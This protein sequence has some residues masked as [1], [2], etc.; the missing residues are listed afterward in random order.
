MTNTDIEV[1]A[2]FPAD[3]AVVEGGKVYSNG[4]FWD[5]LRFPTYPQVFSLSLVAVLKI[6]FRAYHQDHRFEI[7][8]ED[9]DGK[10]LPLR[11][12]GDFR[13]GSSADMRYGDPTVM[14][15]AVNV[16]NVQVAKPADY[17]FVL[18]VDG[19]ELGRY[20]IRAVQL[21]LPIQVPPGTPPQTEPPG[22]GPA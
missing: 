14:P 9:A 13:V 8:M 15:I 3:H 10:E 19:A 22:E 4:A 6:P 18:R 5:R 21:A 17:S 16:N 7:G 1:V 12:Q 20:Q 2:F 11:V